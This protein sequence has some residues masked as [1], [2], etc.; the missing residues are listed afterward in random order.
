MSS[1]LGAIFFAS[2]CFFIAGYCFGRMHAE[3]KN[4]T[5]EMARNIDSLLQKLNH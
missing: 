5:D 4:Q 2:I 3:L 1:I